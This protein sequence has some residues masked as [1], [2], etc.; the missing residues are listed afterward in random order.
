MD[1]IPVRPREPQFS[2]VTGVYYNLGL[3]FRMILNG[4]GFFCRDGVWSSG[5]LVFWSF[6]VLIFTLFDMEFRWRVEHAIF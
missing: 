1:E 5:V 4:F 2:P 3:H 6:G